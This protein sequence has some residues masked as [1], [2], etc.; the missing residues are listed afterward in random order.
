MATR[1]TLPR[2]VVSENPGSTRGTTNSATAGTHATSARSS[3]RSLEAGAPSRVTTAVPNI[4]NVRPPRVTDAPIRPSTAAAIHAIDMEIM[5]SRQR[6][7]GD[8]S[9]S[10]SAGS[11]NHTRSARPGPKVPRDAPCRR[12]GPG[13][14]PE[15]SVAGSR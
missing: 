1:K 12:S 9:L 6:K 8:A 11:G 14:P 5:I 4:L 2:R 13:E 7:P 3:A 10:N 15:W